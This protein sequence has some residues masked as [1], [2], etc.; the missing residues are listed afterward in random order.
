MEIVFCFVDFVLG[1][2]LGFSWVLI[3]FLWFKRLNICLDFCLV[4]FL[5]YNFYSVIYSSND[6]FVSLYLLYF[7]GDCTRALSMLLWIQ[8]GGLTSHRAIHSIARCIK[9]ARN[10]SFL[11]HTKAHRKKH[12]AQ[13]YS[14]C[15]ARIFVCYMS[16]VVLTMAKWAYADVNLRSQWAVVEQRVT[17]T[18]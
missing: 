8:L 14:L 4:I 9:S 3:S 6:L 16:F 10:S 18:S 17:H 1:F 7:A 11:F 15:T 12:W 5:N 13:C 2:S